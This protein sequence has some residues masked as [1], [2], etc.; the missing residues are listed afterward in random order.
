M[1]TIKRYLSYKKKLYLKRFIIADT[2]L[3]EQGYTINL[4]SLQSLKAYL[5]EIRLERKKYL[6]KVVP[7]REE[8]NLK[9][10]K[11]VE[12]TNLFTKEVLIFNSLKETTQY[13]KKY[14]P[15][16]WKVSS[17]T[18]SHNTRTGTPYKNT[19]KLK[20]IN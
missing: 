20:Y 14:S 2:I 13:I 19:F 5:N 4:K 10:C 6:T 8:T 3:N 9:L 16:F 7:S 15:I 18:I 11:K 12:L 1:Y 17:P